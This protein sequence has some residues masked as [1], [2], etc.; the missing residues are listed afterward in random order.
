MK[1]LFFFGAVAVLLAGVGMVSYS[2]LSKYLN[3]GDE[4]KWEFAEIDE[5]AIVAVRNCTGKVEPIQKVVIGSFVSGPIVKI[6]VDHNDEVKKG[7]KLA[8]VDP[9]LFNAN[10]RRD[11]A[12]LTSREADVN[13][14]AALLKQARRDE[15][16]ALGLQQENEDYISQTE[17]DQ[18]VFNVDSLEAQLQIAQASV[19]QAKAALENSQVNLEYTNINAPIDGVILKRTIDPGQ[20]LA[21]AFQTPELF[22]MAPD[23]T[24]IHVFADV[25]EADIG[26]IM[27]AKAADLPVQFTVDAWPGD[28]FEGK[29][30]QIRVSSDPTQVVVTYPVVV[31]AANP[32][33]KLLPGMTATVSFDV[34]RRDKA[35]RIPNKAFRFVPPDKS[36]VREEDHD[37]FEGTLDSKSDDKE[38]ESTLSAA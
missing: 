28:V 27:E 4:P 2:P 9:L 3:K 17:V 26:R 19:E 12:S 37:V 18:Y 21:S 5:G 30:E 14:I 24:S 25:D 1:T 22:T 29:I 32:D 23:M 38:N 35:L 6:Y 11:Q 8:K 20:T 36:D 13:R 15:V 34:A 10:V 16:R 33:L 7:D 31:A